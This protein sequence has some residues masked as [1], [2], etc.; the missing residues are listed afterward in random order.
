MNDATPMLQSIERDSGSSEI[1]LPLVYNELR[2]LAAAKMSR[3][4]AGHT[5]QPTALVH[6][7]W[8]RLVNEGDRTWKNRAQFF[9]AAAEAMRRILIESARRKSRL[10]HGGGQHRL[11]LAD[12]E[13]AATTPDE[14]VLL[15]DDALRQFEVEHPERAHVVMLKYFAGLKNDEVAETL[16]IGERTVDRHWVCA[17]EWLYRKIRQSK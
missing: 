8:I 14:K 13:L 1:L 9:V 17:K 15:I 10:K 7:A 5:L 2:R 6:E 4:A 3:E 11:D 12:V 16:G